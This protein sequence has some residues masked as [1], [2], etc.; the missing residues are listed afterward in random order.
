MRWV[1][2]PVSVG[3]APT[4]TLAKLAA[5]I[6]KKEGGVLSLYGKDLNTYLKRVKVGDVWGIGGRSYKK[7]EKVGVNSAYDFTNLN[8]DWV[9]SNMNITGWRTQQ[10]LLGNSFNYLGENDQMQKSIATTRTF[11]KEIHTLKEL[12]S[13]LSQYISIAARKLR[14]QRASASHI[15]VFIQSYSYKKGSKSYSNSCTVKLPMA[16]WFT[17]ELSRHAMDGLKTIFKPEYGYKRAGV[18]LT[19][20]ESIDSYQFDMLS[21]NNLLEIKIKDQVMRSVDALNSKWGEKVKLGSQILSS[22]WKQGGSFSSPSYTTRWSDL[23][24]V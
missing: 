14:R 12:Q 15:T 18:I 11:K 16:S 20:I 10:E 2:I 8:P 3:I 21:G 6:S 22:S 7:L 24:V 13:A 4:K 1:G 17:P 23:L 19:G 5:G 9:K